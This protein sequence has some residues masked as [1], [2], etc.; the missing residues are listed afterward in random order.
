MSPSPNIPTTPNPNSGTTAPAGSGGSAGGGG[1]GGGGP[2]YL[3]SEVPFGT[4]TLVGSFNPYGSANSSKWTVSQDYIV[5][6]VTGNGG[7]DLVVASRQTQPSTIAD[8]HNTYIQLF[9]W[10]GGKLVND[11]AKWFP[12]GI[13]S[14]LGTDPTVQFADFFHSGKKDM[15]VSPSTD[16]RYYGPAYLFTNNGSSFTRTTIPLNNVWGHGATIAD[17]TNSGYQDVLI[18]DYGA[19]TTLLMNNKVN[20]FTPYT[21]V[22]DGGGQ[23]A[24]RWGGSS[25]TAADYLGN[26]STQIIYTDNGCEVAGCTYPTGR[27][28]GI[29]MYSWSVDPGS[30]QLTFGFVSNLPAATYDHAHLSIN[31]DF[32]ASGKKSIIVFSTPSDYTLKQSA[33]QFFKNDGAG[34][35]ADVTSSML[36]GYNYNTNPTYHPLFVDLGNGQQSMIVSGSDWNGNTSSQILIKNSATGPYTAAFQNLLTDFANEAHQINGSTAQGNQV[37]VVKDASG[38]L[39]LVSTLTKIGNTTNTNSVYISPLGAQVSVATAQGAF[40]QLKATWPYMTNIQANL[41]LAQTSASYMT[42]AGPAQLINTNA[43]VNPYGSL[44][45]VT[46]RG[47]TLGLNG[48]L[49]GVKLENGS[50]IAMDSFGRSFPINLSPTNYQGPN[51]FGSNSEHID[52]FNLSSHSEYLING[53]VNTIPSPVGDLRVGF[54]D[55]NRFNTISGDPNLGATT[56]YNVPK[57]YSIGVPEYYRNGNFSVG[58]QYTSLNQS[59]WMN[60]SGAWGS[61]QNSGNLEHVFTYRQGGFSSQGAL[62]RTTTAI[63]PGMITQVTP[64]IGAWA[65]T[66]YRHADFG[67]LGDMGVYLGVKPVVLS[68]SLTANVPTGTD[69]AGNSMYTQMKMGVANTVLPYLR[70]LYAN[71]IDRQTIYRLSGMVSPNGLFRVMSELRY[72]FD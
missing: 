19:N 11:T 3:R 53:S 22:F 67:S 65:E 26:G 34:N 13:N 43:L 2:T 4:P 21:A 30:N 18:S 63:T 56:A 5:D 41:V 49:S 7:Q 46:N 24:L 28:N 32:D 55:R 27:T 39:Y 35:F 70:T 42:D 50:A 29:H 23:K 12:G 60:F 37:N 6:G 10:Q 36:I 17:L 68:G 61:V 33:I 72:S 25:L 48:Y 51:G 20:G 9:D 40:N 66:G 44:G 1:G 69:S 15:F 52:Q 54:E 8:W 45:V 58:V 47:T 64:I 57:Q 59:P 16:M 71:N 14:I 31:Y 38:N 62:T